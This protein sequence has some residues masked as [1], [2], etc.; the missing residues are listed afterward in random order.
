[1]TDTQAA[2][3]LTG[4]A[5]LEAEMRDRLADKNRELERLR[6]SNKQMREALQQAVSETEAEAQRFLGQGYG[7]PALPW[8]ANACAALKDAQGDKT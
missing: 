7:L 1:M 8:L 6:A 5:A 2:V 4:I 3:G